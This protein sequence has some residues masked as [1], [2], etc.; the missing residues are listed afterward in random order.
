MAS[1]QGSKQVI[2]FQVSVGRKKVVR[3]QVTVVRGRQEAQG[4]ER[5]A[6]S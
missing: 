5:G 3:C 2:R 6:R 4:S 1:Y